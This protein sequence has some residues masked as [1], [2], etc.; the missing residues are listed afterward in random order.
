[1]GITFLRIEDHPVVK[2]EST[3]TKNILFETKDSHAWIHCY[4]TP[5]DK[6][7]LHCHNADQTSRPAAPRRTRAISTTRPEWTRERRRARRHVPIAEASSSKS[8]TMM[9]QSS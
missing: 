8:E 6:D 7:D 5:G 4:K 3:L 1:M 9:S 2:G